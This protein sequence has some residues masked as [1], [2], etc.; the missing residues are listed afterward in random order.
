MEFTKALQ[1]ATGV[2]LHSSMTTSQSWSM[3]ET[4]CTTPD[5]VQK[6]RF[7]HI[8]L[9]TLWVCTVVQLVALLPCS[10]K[11]L[12]S[13]PGLGSFCMEFAASYSGFLPQFKDM[14]VRLIGLSKLP[15]GV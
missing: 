14:P 12:G 1:V 11:V 4:L 7:D 15:L 5:V 6:L 10:K 8:T 3:L 2:L 9:I 13:I